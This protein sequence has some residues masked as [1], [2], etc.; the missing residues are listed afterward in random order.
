MAW[1]RRIVTILV[2][3]TILALVSVLAIWVNRI[4]LDTHTW[5]GTS[6]VLI[7]DDEVRAALA[8]TL[9]DSLYNSVGIAEQHG[10]L[11]LPL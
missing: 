10:L 6:D 8:A 2:L 3:G 9:T 1:S 4:A 5:V 7:A 11:P